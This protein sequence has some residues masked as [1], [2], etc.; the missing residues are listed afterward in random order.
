M[1]AF[2]QVWELFQRLIADGKRIALASSA[3]E[4]EL[5]HYK[6]VAHIYDLIDAETSSDDADRSKPHPDIFQAALDHFPDLDRA[7]AI[8]KASSGAMA[9]LQCTRTRR[10][11]WPTTKGRRSEDAEAFA[12]PPRAACS[13]SVR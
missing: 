2:P 1:T 7:S 9:A 6:K 3:K 13:L 11:F 8:V 10:T 5:E 4:D 12:V